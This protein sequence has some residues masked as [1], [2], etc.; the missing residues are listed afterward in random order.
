MSQREEETKLT[1]NV[2][3][4]FPG[5]PRTARPHAHPARVCACVSVVGRE[6]AEGAVPQ[7]V[8]SVCNARP[9]DGAPIL[10]P[11]GLK[12]VEWL[13]VGDALELGHRVAPRQREGFSGRDND[14][15]RDV[16][17][18]VA[19]AEYVELG[20]GRGL[21]L[22]QLSVGRPRPGRKKRTN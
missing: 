15:G 22:A 14:F 6:E 12:F 21:L 20:V 1:N 9:L 11:D 7:I 4:G 5:Q 13:G 17:A 2:D 19:A 16:H 18:V 3:L 10:E 8:E